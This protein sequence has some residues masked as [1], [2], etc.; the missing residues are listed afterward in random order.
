MHHVATYW[1]NERE[2]FILVFIYTWANI[3]VF[4]ER[5]YAYFY[6]NRVELLHAIGI[7]VPIAR[8]C[9]AGIK[10]NVG[11][12]LFLTLRNEL[13]WLQ[14]TKFGYYIPF[15]KLKSFHIHVA[16][17]IAIYAIVHVFSHYHNFYIIE[18]TDPETLMSIGFLPEGADVAPTAAELLYTTIPGVTGVSLVLCMILIYTS[19]VEIVREN[20][21]DI[22]W[23]M[24]HVGV[25]F[26]ILLG[27]HGY[28][29]L[30][31]PPSCWVWFIGPGLL[32][33]FERTL[34]IFR[35]GKTPR[36]ISATFYP[37]HV[38]ELTLEK[39]IDYLPG[40]YVYICCPFISNFQ[41]HPF[42]ISSSPHEEHILLHIKVQGD[43]TR[44]L[45]NLLL[46]V[47]IETH[48][49]NI[50]QSP[51]GK[52]ILLID[53]PFA[54][55]SENIFYFDRALIICTGIGST[56]FSS[57]LK[58]VSHT[59]VTSKLDHIHIHWIVRDYSSF[60]WFVDILEE[61]DS[62]KITIGVHVTGENDLD[63][64]TS[65]L[66]IEFGRPDMDTIFEELMDFEGIIGVFYC[67][68]AS[69]SKQLYKLCRKKSNQKT[70]FHY[71]KESF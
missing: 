3:L 26:F 69:L 19:S 49:E 36:I 4:G 62:E 65:S 15:E 13:S 29:A 2:K 46:D 18:N 38:L 58:Y 1:E 64:D 44:K 25:L 41:W 32:Y 52:P 39:K 10:L 14:S 22:F 21:F 63:I 23:Y 42:T 12:L 28:A 61:T 54:S 35:K 17:H 31:E 70:I 9:G 59:K 50:S 30:L 20:M 56:P 47:T 11:I 24:H 71:H 27:L 37:S 6:G 60:P 48:V 67:G 55:S 43:W 40:Q 33:I 68:P 8:A 34:R 45:Q 5:F 7:G 66:D 16:V 51:D 57:I 53:G